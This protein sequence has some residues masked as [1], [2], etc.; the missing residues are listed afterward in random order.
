MFV[1]SYFASYQILA[2]LLPNKL[3]LTVKINCVTV[4]YDFVI[5]N[6]HAHIYL[7][8]NLHSAYLEKYFCCD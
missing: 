7:F 3:L 2:K 6:P 8:Y 1:E 4:K 5:R